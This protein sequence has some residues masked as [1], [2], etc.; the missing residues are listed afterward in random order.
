MVFLNKLGTHG[1]GS[2]SIGT[3]TPQPILNISALVNLFWVL[4]VSQISVTLSLGTPSLGTFW[5]KGPH[6]F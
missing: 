3:P 4:P 5:T 2:L 1:L 6:D